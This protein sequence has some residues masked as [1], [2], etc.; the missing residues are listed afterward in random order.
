MCAAFN[1][2]SSPV[3]DQMPIEI[4]E[5]DKHHDQT[6]IEILKSDEHHDKASC[7]Y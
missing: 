1:E 6:P 2:T 4:L 5:S 7:K 3:P